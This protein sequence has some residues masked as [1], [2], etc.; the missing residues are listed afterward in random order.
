M[1]SVLICTWNRG[2]L[3]H[4]TLKSLIED[5][6]KKADEIVVVNGGG[7]KDCSPT[8]SYWKDRC[9]YLR[10]V[11]TQNI[12]LANSRNI[13]LKA[14]KG[15]L[16]LMTDDDARVF[17]DW[18]EK[19]VKAHQGFPKA[20]VIGGEVVDASGESLLSHI[21]DITTFPRYNKR[22]EVRHVPGVNCSFKR[23]VIDAIGEQDLQ[24]FRGEDV[25]YTWKAQRA[26]WKVLYDPDIK[27]Y[28]AHRPTWKG[29]FHQHHMYGRAYYR[30]REKWKDMYCAYPR[31]LRTPRMWAKGLYYLAS[32]WLYAWQKAKKLPDLKE[33]LSGYFII[34]AISYYTMYGTFL[35]WRIDTRQQA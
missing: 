13:G 25:D 29:L 2:D 14:V 20:G 12:N 15:D 34:T 26:G 10:E 35:Q 21:A 18:I 8:L 6:I 7:E 32:P 1:T 17:P 9:D 27:V 3:I 19:M 30:V 11:K 22:T 16:I 4:A 28:H 33:R 31:H 5:S 24:L 23:E